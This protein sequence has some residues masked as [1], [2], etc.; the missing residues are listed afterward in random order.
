LFLT[1]KRGYIC[2]TSGALLPQKV[3]TAAL[4]FVS[5]TNTYFMNIFVAKLS[6]RTRVEELQQAFSEFGEVVSAKIII[7]RETGKS[8]QFGFVEMAN[9]D[10]ALTAIEQLNGKELNGHAMVVSKA[11]PR[12][13]SSGPGKGGF[14]RP[15]R[16][17]F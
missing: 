11:Q 15:R 16:K 6:S 9:D 14:Q 8:K 5:L 7:D 10:E 4:P 17:D 2:Y 3:N 1:V 13:R 12:E